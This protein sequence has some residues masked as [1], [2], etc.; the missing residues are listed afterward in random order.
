MYNGQPV[1]YDERLLHPCNNSCIYWLCGRL[2]C[3]NI[4]ILSLTDIVVGPSVR[5][6]AVGA[7]A[8]DR[9]PVHVQD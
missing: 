6:P 8:A 2:C 5:M 9:P 4:A 7:V 3:N 1:Q